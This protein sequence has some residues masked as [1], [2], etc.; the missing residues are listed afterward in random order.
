MNLQQL[1]YFQKIAECQQYTLAARELHVTQ[2]TLSYAISNLEQE[3]DAK[4]FD[5]KGKSVC[6]TP[7][8]K[9]YLSCVRDALQALERGKQAVRHTTS[10]AKAVVR[11]SY[12]ES[13]KHLILNLIADLYAEEEN[14]PLRFELL[15]S[16]A[17]VI[18]QQLI[19]RETDLGISTLPAAEGISSHL[20]GHQD[21]VVI[22]PK[23]HSWAHRDSVSLSD[24]DGQRFIAYNRECIIRGYYDAILDAAH[25]RP[26]I[27]AESRFHSN[28]LDMVSFNMG[29]ALV[30]RMKRLEERYDL[31]ALPIRDSI[32]PRA[33]YLLW[34][35]DAALPP[36]VEAFRQGLL[37]SGNL[38]RYL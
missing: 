24:L 33:I 30:P 3:L 11:L 6:L 8:G 32:P 35:A 31:L 29:V 27:F 21:N 9:V 37:E 36:A 15:P 20:I 4:L 19:R 1:Y 2:A 26:E 13:V 23:Q 10:P 22:V 14:A 38:A 25:V 5:R 34:A 7:C 17:P 28:I 16:N 18:E 12:L